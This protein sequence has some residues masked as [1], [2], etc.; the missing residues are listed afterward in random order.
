MV[1][2]VSE[3]LLQNCHMRWPNSFVTASKSPKVV[4]VCNLSFANACHSAVLYSR[5]SNIL[6]NGSGRRSLNARMEHWPDW[7]RHQYI[8]EFVSR[9]CVHLENIFEIT[10]RKLFHLRDVVVKAADCKPA[11]CRNLVESVSYVNVQSFYLV[12]TCTL[13]STRLLEHL[14]I[15]MLHEE[16]RSGV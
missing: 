14:V 6:L 5:Q 8:G 16:C 4:S 15:Q 11:E 7:D 13:Y 10:G 2:N 9:T 12:F 1:L 3:V